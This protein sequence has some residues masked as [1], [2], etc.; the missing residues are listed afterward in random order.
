MPQTA[1]DKIYNKY[2]LQASQ[3][4]GVTDTVASPSISPIAAP[5]PQASIWDV[6]DTGQYPDWYQPLQDDSPAAGLMNAVGVGLWSFVDTALFGVPGSLVEEERFLDFE[7]PVAKWTGAIGGFVGFVGGA[8][9]KVGT[10]IAQK[11]FGVLAKTALK[12]EGKESVETVIRGMRERGLDGGL[13]RGAVKKITTGYK[14]LVKQAAVDPKLR[15]AE[16]SRVTKEYLEEY[17]RRGDITGA[18]AQA[19][20]DVF[21]ANVFKRPL[22]DFKAL[23]KVRG[24]ARTNPR[25]A[26]VI[27]HSIDDAIVFGAIDT[28]FEGVSMIEDRN[29]DWTAPLWGAGTGIAFGQLG[30]LKPRGKAASFKKDFIAG[31]KSA[32]AR[33][34]TFDNKTRQY[35][36]N[37]S[38]LYGENLTRNGES[39]TVPFK[40]LGKESSGLNLKSTSLYDDIEKIWG[41]D[42]EKALKAL[43]EKEKKKW[44]RS[45]MKWATTEELGNM[46]TNWR[47]MMLGGVLF[48]VHTLYDTYAHDLEPDVNDILP[49]FLIGAYVQRRSNPAKFDIS[50]KEM[51]KI[52]QNLEILGQSPEQFATIPTF[53]YAENR[54]ENPFLD[55]K[56]DE[57]RRRLEELEIVTDVHEVSST[58]LPTDV[59]SAA[60]PEGQNPVFDRMYPFMKGL[61]NWRKPLDNISSKDANE[62]A[63][64]ILKV[65]SGFETTQGTNKA[66]EKTFIKTQERFE[67]S[68]KELIES[69]EDPENIL[70]ITSVD[71]KLQT[72]KYF[73]IHESMKK[74]AKDGELE[75]LVDEN[76]VKLKGEE[77]LDAL[78]DKA[79]GFNAALQT[80]WAVGYADVLPVESVKEVKSE[81]LLKQ[82]HEKVSSF[83]TNVEK[84]FPDNDASA[85]RFSL[86]QGYRDYVGILQR[87]YGIRTSQEILSIFKPEFGDRDNLLSRLIDARVL[88]SPGKISEALIVDDV[89]KIEIIGDE[90]SNVISKDRRFLGKVLTLQSSV[91]GYREFEIDPNN[92]LKVKHS[93]VEALR[94]Y[95]NGYKVFIDKIPDHLQSHLTNFAFMERVEG[96]KLEINEVDALFNL[97]GV[98]GAKFGATAQDRTVGFRV[99][100]IDESRISGHHDSAL[101]EMAS[102]YNRTLRR[103]IDN[104][105]GIVVESA[106]KITVVEKSYMMGLSN[107]LKIAGESSINAKKALAE[108]MTL[109]SA[110][111]RGFTS[112]KEQL[113]SFSNANPGNDFAVVKWLTEAKVFKAKEDLRDYDVDIDAFNELLKKDPDF[114]PDLQQKMNSYGYDPD[115]AMAKYAA[116]EQKGKDNLIEDSTERGYVPH[117]D[118]NTFYGRYRIDGKDA[119]EWDSSTKYN[120]FAALVYHPMAGTDKLLDRNVVRKVLDRIHVK[121]DDDFVSFRDDLEPYEQKA[122]LPEIRQDLIG[123][124]GSQR[125]QVKLD[126]FSFKGGDYRKEQQVLQLTRL[127]SYLDNVLEIPYM[128]VDGRID[129]TVVSANGRSYVDRQINIFEDSEALSIDSRR[130]VDKVKQ[131]FLAG[132]EQESSVFS[133]E[134]GRWELEGEGVDGRKYRGLTLIN[135]SPNVDPIVVATK[136]LANLREPFKEFVDEYKGIEGLSG[137]GVKTLK[138]LESKIDNNEIIT[139]QESEQMMTHLVMKEM[140]TGSDGDRIFLGFLN[141]TNAEKLFLRSKLFNTKK[142]VRYNKS[143]IQDVADVYMGDPT[144]V[145]WDTLQDGVTAQVLRRIVRNDGFGISIWNDAQYATIK[146]EV[147]AI[148]DRL[149]IDWSYDSNIGRAHE[150]VSSYDS[151]SFVSRSM[152][153]FVHTMLGHD[154]LSFNPVKPIITSGGKDS[155]LLLGKTLFVYS[156]SLDEFF[157][158]N[159]SID[160]LLTKTGSKVINPVG[161]AEDASLINV[162][163]DDLNSQRLTSEKIRKISIESLG[164]MPNK[165]SDFVLAKTSQA[166]ANFMNDTESGQRFNS[167]FAEQLNININKMTEVW[168]DPMSVRRWILAELGDDALVADLEAGEG[169]KAISN[170]AVY[171]ALTPDANPSSY[172]DRYVKNK[173]YNIYIDSVING[174]K[175][176]TNQYNTEDSHRYG[177]QSPV[178]QDIGSRYRLNPTLVDRAGEVKLQGEAMLPSYAAKLSIRE[179][180]ESEYKV[181]FVRLG[182]TLRPEDVIGEEIWKE[183]LDT[184]AKLGTL[185]EYVD[186]MKSKGE[187]ADDVYIGVMVRRNPRTRPNDFALMGLKGFLEKTHG[188]ALLVNSFDIANVMEGDYDFDKSDFFF[189]HRES[190]WNHVE[191]ASKFFVQ[192]VDPSKYQKPIS[193]NLGMNATD[194]AGAKRKM[195]SNANVYK[196]SIGIVQK[197]PRLLGYV[198]KLGAEGVGNTAVERFN[199][200]H[201]NT[202]FTKPKILL[203]GNPEQDFMLV[204]DYE[205]KDYFQRAAL[206]TQLIVDA[207][208]DLNRDILKGDIYGWRED[209]LFP[210]RDKSFVP[211]ELAQR[212]QAGFINDM[213]DKGNSEG[214]RI[215]IFRKIVRSADGWDETDLTNLDRAIVSQMMSEYGKLLN[216]TK[217]SVYEN[218]GEQRKSEYTDVLGASESFFNFNST[219]NR[220]LYWR[221]KN[222]WGSNQGLKETPWYKDGDFKSYFGVKEGFHKP[223]NKRYWYSTKNVLHP[224]V[225]NHGAEFNSGTRGAPVDRILWDFYNRDPFRATTTRIVGGRVGQLIDEWYNELLG[226]GEFTTVD[227]V[228]R[229]IDRFET[230]ADKLTREVKKGLGDYNRKAQIISNVQ[231]KIETLRNSKMRWDAKKTAIEKLE[232]FVKKIESEIGIDFLPYEYRKSHDAKDLDKMQVIF[233]DEKN[234]IDGTVYYATLENVKNLLPGGWSLSPDAQKDL[235]FI[236]KIRKLFYGNKTRLKDFMRYGGKTLLT[237]QEQQLVNKFPDFNTF[238]EV[239]TKLLVQGYGKYGP[240]F[241]YAYMQPSQNKKAVGVF[242]N[243]PVSVPYQSTDTFDPSSKYRRGIRL[244]TAIASGTEETIQDAVRNKALAKQQLSYVQFIESTFSRFFN[245]RVDQKW[246]FGEEI[247][248]FLDVG[249]IGKS[250]KMAIYNNL[251]LPNFNKDFARLFSDFRSVQWQRDA[252]S[253]SS[254]FGVMNDHVIDFYSNVMRLAGKEKEYESYLEKMSIMD[255]QLMRNEVINPMQYLLLR[256]N[257]DREVREIAG[258]VFIGG[259]L[260][261][262]FRNDNQVAKNIMESPVYVMMGG[263]DYYKRGISLEKPADTEYNLQKLRD[264]KDMYESIKEMKKDLNPNVSESKDLI[265][266]I[267]IKCRGKV[268]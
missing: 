15:G 254:G 207:S 122:R 129:V 37:K 226:G 267:K 120:E 9:L 163:A 187:I 199:E 165:D 134:E 206:E 144:Q 214:K 62:I 162:G 177:G 182:K 193:Y 4:L 45:M 24:L 74:K 217:D 23:M 228:T 149:G 235:K 244:L 35:L 215:R 67:E 96:T 262:E 124:L 84:Q 123:L 90:D 210:S 87:N 172:S 145:T 151:I 5:Q 6:M 237:T 209:F 75:W 240:T 197:V 251:R 112:F 80:S 105:G 47:R 179:L 208:G 43:L 255:S 77:A 150:D 78:Y 252:N 95:L 125:A 141:G 231:K 249:A 13:S 79:D 66:L 55:A 111:K 184:D 56:F 113:K 101:K 221:L 195:I 220:S 186:Y 175:S 25:L 168:Q 238:Y 148:V 227:D 263:G 167:E 26:R 83:E 245:N 28:I 126:I 142:Y 53:E 31:V 20:R 224:D 194:A 49:S 118:L 222:K 236:R 92:P 85:E 152:M 127:N 10:K 33:K 218:T 61:R 107:A 115:Y 58:E 114:L 46:A 50:H 181:R 248:D 2:K 169:M 57:V 239:E 190:M 211:N 198:D 170:M 178:I 108:F 153:R 44:G 103:M 137:N 11:G 81:S 202:K 70:G 89:K 147:R 69:I 63:D 166:D 34:G 242:H 27:G 68:F 94:K 185:Q 265:E 86:S 173:M 19:V 205:H 29:F 54:L 160:I 133:M 159:R 32:F 143:F 223:T 243:R 109:L 250:G 157:K 73:T 139:P 131:E 12:K 189:A 76:G 241:L 1:S 42:S 212:N 51:N 117:I 106:D 7:D 225:K 65:D 156:E 52:R 119:S 247:G 260:Q 200:L 171:A 72:P 17:L 266:E 155:P 88:Y 191:R 246:L 93:E 21:S 232:K 99:K 203:G 59:K 132:I 82:I 64:L 256:Q 154:P 201:P 233:A 39:A 104:G 219:I 30:W 180:N 60:V 91:G 110:Q 192:G 14:S 38:V 216:V 22:Q 18:Q 146:D 229:S 234:V 100:L 176:A 204:M 71:G 253:M 261:R 130:R 116:N 121:K 158:N 136:D 174:M 48:N 128:F 213:R 183:T 264:L 230:E 259:L 161:D 135:I 8:P 188:N 102:D 36:I 3:S 97:S 140:L 257:L 258:D 196:K 40:F 138:A 164:L 268:I 98:G 41:K 16:F